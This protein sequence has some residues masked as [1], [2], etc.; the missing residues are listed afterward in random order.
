MEEEKRVYQG[1]GS[2]VAKCVIN[3][4]ILDCGKQQNLLSNNKSGQSQ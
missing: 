2:H 3:V 4:V 1:G